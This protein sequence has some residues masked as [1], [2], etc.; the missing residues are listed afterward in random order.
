MW[1]NRTR[2]PFALVAALPLAVC[3]SAPG[4]LS[5]RY[6]VVQRGNFVMIGNTLGHDGAMGV[7]VPLEGSFGGFGI[8]LADSSPDVYWYVVTAQTPNHVVADNTVTGYIARTRAILGIPPGSVVTYARLY[9]GGFVQPGTTPTPPKGETVHTLPGDRFQFSSI[10]TGNVRFYGP[11]PYTF[12]CA[13]E[14]LAH[15]VNADNNNLFAGWSMVVVY[16]HPDEP[17]REI[18][19]ADGFEEVSPDAPSLNSL[20][21]D[22][23]PLAGGASRLGVFAYEGDHTESGDEIRV[24]GLPI[25]DAANPMNNPFNGSRTVLGVPATTSGDLPWLT[26]APASMCGIDLDVF[27]ISSHLSPVAGPVQIDFTTTGDV[28]VLGYAALSIEADAPPCPPDADGD[29]DHDFADLTTILTNFGNTGPPHIP[30]DANGDGV[31]NFTDVP[32]IL[33]AWGIVCP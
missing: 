28:Y 2:L 10:Q 29:G 11:G 5:I 19:L 33:A 26:G 15:L 13:I 9:R 21:L 20:A 7:P 32:P 6:H 30:G 23:P 17:V 14:N 12:G 31:V 3:F 4:A 1:N 18:I 25:G 16:R 22:Y 8:N 27:D 24:A